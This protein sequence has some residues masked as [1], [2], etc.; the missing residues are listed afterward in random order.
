MES[1]RSF[2]AMVR[3]MRKVYPQFKLMMTDDYGLLA[4]GAPVVMPS[5]TNDN[6][7]L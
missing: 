4:V 5:P 2:M 3:A 6:S 1:F 7:S